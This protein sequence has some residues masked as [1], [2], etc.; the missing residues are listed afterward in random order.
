MAKGGREDGQS[1]QHV[2]GRRAANVVAT[3][4]GCRSSMEDNIAQLWCLRQARNRGTAWQTPLHET[5][6][7]TSSDAIKLFVSM[8]TRYAA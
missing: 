6:A 8:P 4:R 7:R 5:D 3:D 2:L 1:E